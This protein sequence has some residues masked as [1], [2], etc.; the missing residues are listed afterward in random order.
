MLMTTE[1]NRRRNSP[2]IQLNMNSGNI[3]Q[4]ESGQ[5]LGVNIHQDLKWSNYIFSGDDCSL[6]KTLNTRLKALKQICTTAD[7]K[8][9]LQI[10]NG[11]FMSKLIYCIPLWGGTSVEMIR[12]LQV[13]QNKAARYITKLDWY[14]P[15]ETLMKQCN[16]FN[17]KQ[18]I[19]YHSLLSLHKNLVFNQ[20]MY[21]FK[22][23]DR[24][25][26]RNTRLAQSGNIRL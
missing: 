13:V 5:L 8:T 18:L 24:S 12:M 7:F 6:V 17:I 25:F 21:M 23:L 11:I 10:A 1:T 16:W 19:A 26:P 20:P 3:Q 22:K 9:R 2:H 14:T 15:S 4:I